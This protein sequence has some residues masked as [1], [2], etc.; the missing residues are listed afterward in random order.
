M[1][2]YSWFLVLVG[3]SV[4]LAWCWDLDA[5][6]FEESGLGFAIASF[7]CAAL[8]LIVSW[9]RTGRVLYDYLVAS[10]PLKGTDISLFTALILTHL[11]FL[12]FVV[13]LPIGASICADIVRNK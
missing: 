3:A 5:S 7:A 12:V 8:A 13:A 11:T 9:Q 2:E 10:L 6:S 1:L 4:A